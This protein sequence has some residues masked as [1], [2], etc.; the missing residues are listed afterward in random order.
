MRFIASAPPKLYLMYG[1]SSVCVLVSCCAATV[2]ASRTSSKNISLKVDFAALITDGV[3]TVDL[4][5]QD[6]IIIA[7][8]YIFLTCVGD[9]G[10]PHHS[11]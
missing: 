1:Y 6:I 11:A 9:E 10:A 2:M 3:L 5:G 4:H 7:L 8:T